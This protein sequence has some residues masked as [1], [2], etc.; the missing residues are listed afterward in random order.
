MT[1][2]PAFTRDLPFVA[3]AE[4][5]SLGSDTP[6]V[7]L[8]P[9]SFAMSDFFQTGAIATLHRLGKHDR[10]DGAKLDDAPDAGGSGR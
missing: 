5:K 8:C 4:V 1:T 3:A 9:P 6:P 7:P 2:A 10:V